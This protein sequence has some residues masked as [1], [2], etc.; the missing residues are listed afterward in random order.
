LPPETW[1]RCFLGCKPGLTGA[2]FELNLTF[3]YHRLAVFVS[4]GCGFG[5]QYDGC[6]IDRG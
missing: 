1:I 2:Q 5:P 3:E 4:V 6:T